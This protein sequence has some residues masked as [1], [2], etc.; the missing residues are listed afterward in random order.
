M[1]CSA[2]P[3]SRSASGWRSNGRTDARRFEAAQRATH[4][5]A[6]FATYAEAVRQ[7]PSYCERMSAAGRLG[8]TEEL[9]VRIGAGECLAQM[10][11]GIPMSQGEMVRPA[12]LGLDAARSRRA[13]R[14]PST[15]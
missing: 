13:S 6:W 1:R 7:L 8:E 4:G 12:D 10:A 14:R 9:L 5:L 11:G 2:M 3:S 15:S